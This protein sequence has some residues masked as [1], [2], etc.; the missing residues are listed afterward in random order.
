VLW[1]LPFDNYNGPLVYLKEG[2][3]ILIGKDKLK[4][5]FTPGHSP[6]SVS[7][8]NEAGG[9]IIGGDVL[10]NGS[11]GRTD[12]PGADP[13]TLAESIKRE[14]YNLPEETVVYPGHGPTTTVGFE[15]KNNPYVKMQ[16]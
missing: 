6:G 10:F 16:M 14:F 7:F 1:Q 8:Y 12:L 4:V 2:N 13:D 3:N 15:K 11:I 9:F 5:C